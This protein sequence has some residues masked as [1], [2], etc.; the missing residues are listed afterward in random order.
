MPSK[1]SYLT[2]IFYPKMANSKHDGARNMLGKSGVATRIKAEQPNAP[3]FLESSFLRSTVTQLTSSCEVLSDTMGTVGEIRALVMFS[4][5]RKNILG[6]ILKP[7]E[8][9]L[10]DESDAS[11]CSSLDQMYILSV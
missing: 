1:M 8:G 10:V 5:E 2:L 7:V 3:A 9:K 11:Q 4:T 6:T